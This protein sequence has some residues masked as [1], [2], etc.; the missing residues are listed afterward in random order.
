MRD[1]KEKESER[2]KERERG[3]EG[4]RGEGERE[5]GKE[6]ERCASHVLLYALLGE[7]G[8]SEDGGGM[9]GALRWKG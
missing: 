5:R 3:R 1:G 4:E 7:F 8:S 9:H 6:R 2:K